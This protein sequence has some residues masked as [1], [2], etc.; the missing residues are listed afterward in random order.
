MI[1]IP[2]Y[3]MASRPRKLFPF[4]FGVIEGYLG[5]LGEF[6]CFA[7]FSGQENTTNGPRSVGG[8]LKI[9]N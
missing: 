1:T 2:D 7:K 9:G 3:L 8:Y 6:Q 5:V 4:D